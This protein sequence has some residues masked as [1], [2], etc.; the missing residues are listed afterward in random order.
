MVGWEEGLEVQTLTES[1][2]GLGDEI[3]LLDCSRRRHTPTQGSLLDDR[4]L[5]GLLLAGILHQ[6]AVAPRQ[7]FHL[8]DLGAWAS[9]NGST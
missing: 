4:L 2:T 1:K 9:I 8:L 3:Y 7:E 5:A 6:D